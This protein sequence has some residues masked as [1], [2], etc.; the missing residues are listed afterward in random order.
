[1]DK[2]DIQLE[3]KYLLRWIPDKAYVKLYFR[4][5]QKRKLK[6][7][8]PKTLNEKLNWMKFNYRKPLFTILSDK[9]EVRKYVKEKIGEEYLI[10][11]LG[12]W[13]KFEE[14]DFEKLPSE[15]ILKTN[16][17]SGGYY[18]FKN[19]SKKNIKK[20][21]NKLN[22]H[23]KRNFYYIGREWQYKN[24]KRCIV[25][26]KLLKD[27]N[28][29]VPDDYKITCYNGKCDNI[30]VCDGR[31]SKEGVK[32]YF[33]DR[34]WRFLRYIKGDDKLPENF[35]LEKPKN[36]E[37][38]IEVAEKLSE[39]LSYARIDLYNLNGTIYFG[40]I[41]LCPNSG[42]DNDITLEADKELGKKIEI[43]NLK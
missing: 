35:T 28:G 22:F 34:N 16:H 30:M 14:I 33:F 29:N 8:N 2:S 18:I 40:E 24:I 11:L 5:N 12:K 3:T 41:T 31:Q 6:F 36:L 43:S 25:A 9:Y 4:L 21:K 26:E 27:K 1:M 15:F 7:E 13:D 19:K 20:A 37:E 17:D 39:D 23:L 38:M 32:F 10:P 42:F